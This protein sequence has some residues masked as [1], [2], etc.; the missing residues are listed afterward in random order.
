V[1]VAII[2]TEGTSFTVEAWIKGL[3]PIWSPKTA[4]YE[5]YGAQGTF[6]SFQTEHTDK[7]WDSWAVYY[8]AGYD[9][10]VFNHVVFQA[11]QVGADYIK[12]IYANGNL[13]ASRT[14]SGKKL[15]NWL[16]PLRIGRYYVESTF[17][18]G[19]IDEVRIYNRALSADEIK[20]CYNLGKLKRVSV[21]RLVKKMGYAGW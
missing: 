13:I 21:P 3:G 11:E 15:D 18:K 7:T 4:R 19:I 2:P 6:W 8:P 10:A 5:Y 17:F 12:R 14:V 1:P 20:E 9:T 16:S